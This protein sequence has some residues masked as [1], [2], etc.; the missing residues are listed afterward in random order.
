MAE[1]IADEMVLDWVMGCECDAE[2]R[3]V[4]SYLYRNSTSDNY[5]TRTKNICVCTGCGKMISISGKIDEI[6]DISMVSK[7]R[8]YEND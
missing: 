7:V 6:A 8:E 3:V 4:D 2:I 1:I 5:V